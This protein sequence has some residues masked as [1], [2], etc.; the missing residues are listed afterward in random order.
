MQVI[1]KQNNKTVLYKI[2]KEK[3]K[4]S[5]LEK[6]ELE[7]ISKLSQKTYIAIWQD[8]VD[9]I[10]VETPKIK[11]KK[12]IENLIKTNLINQIG[13]IVGLEINYKPINQ[14]GQ[15]ILFNV[16]TLQ[17]SLFYEFNIPP[18]YY[19]KIEKFTSIPFSLTYYNKLIEEKS[20]LHFYI[21]DNVFIAVFT[22][23]KVLDF[24]RITNLPQDTKDL[25]TLENIILT[26]RYV[27]ANIAAP[28]IIILSGERELFNRISDEIYKGLNR[29]FCELNYEYF[30]KDNPEELII[31]VGILNLE[32]TYNFLPQK[33]KK[34]KSLYT[35]YQFLS[36]ILLLLNLILFLKTFSLTSQ[37]LNK[38]FS[39]Q[40]IQQEN[41]RLEKKLDS[42]IAGK[43][44]Q[45]LTTTYNLLQEKNNHIKSLNEILK[46][47]KDIQRPYE[48]FKYTFQQG[49]YTI[50]L[51]YSKSF[52]TYKEME[53]YV[54]SIKSN[55]KVA[56]KD[57]K[58]KTVKVKVNY[59]N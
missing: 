31:P 54:E 43:D 1:L 12:L 26:Y 15:S 18:K 5:L 42:M 13:N 38:Y 14:E 58:T 2:K 20:V 11:N 55:N 37:V 50:T 7:S 44:I 27:N 28:D 10:K 33:I 57:Y 46:L 40:E 23:N 9:I 19:P 3:K 29:P 6:I 35:I 53:M 49:K 59:G 24:V 39:M 25:S 21:K 16:F 4:Y 51:S 48:N 36:V 45:F 41:S 17:E 32:E 8:V 52:K 22:V 47:E 56:E 30:F 34:E